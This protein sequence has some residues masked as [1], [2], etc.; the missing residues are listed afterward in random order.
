MTEVAIL[1]QYKYLSTQ[2]ANALLAQGDSLP[3]IQHSLDLAWMAYGYEC[4]I[5]REGIARVSHFQQKAIPYRE[6]ALIFWKEAKQLFQRV[7]A[8]SIS[9]ERAWA[10]LGQVLM[11]VADG[12][13]Q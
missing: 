12:G 5:V 11:A 13:A 6:Q 8:L 7:D 10:N 9:E 1:E 2:S 3:N 4:L